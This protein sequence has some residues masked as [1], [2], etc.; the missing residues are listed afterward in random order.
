M[1]ATAVKMVYYEK[2]VPYSISVRM[3]PGDSQ[4]KL[5]S[6]SQTWVGI[7]EDLLRDFKL[8]NKKAIMDG[9][10]RPIDE[11]SVDWETPNTYS[12][13]ELGELLKNMMKLKKA[14]KEIDAI[15]TVIRIME[16]AKTTNKSQAMIEVIQEKIEELNGDD[17]I[18]LEALGR[19]LNS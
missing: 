13:E 12:D 19:N 5:L 10:I 18:T 7:R 4:G 2:T 15:P 11:P 17:A 9:L 14:L 16:M 8:A 3:F 6:H 1:D